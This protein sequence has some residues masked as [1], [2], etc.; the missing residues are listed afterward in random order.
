M[1]TNAKTIGKRL[2]AL[3]A[4]HVTG[5]ITQEH[6]LSLLDDSEQYV[7]AW[8]IQFLAEGK[9]PSGAVRAKFSQMARAETSP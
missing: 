6:A 7:R 4:L 5:G 9:K 3:W 8:T 1:L 2:R